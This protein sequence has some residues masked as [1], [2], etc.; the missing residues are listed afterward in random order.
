M[1]KIS[2]LDAGTPTGS[3]LIA[4]AQGATTVKTTI[5]DAVKAGPVASTSVNGLM[6]SGDKTKLDGLSLIHI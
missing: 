4:V 3:N 6:S 5:A 1:P 2:E